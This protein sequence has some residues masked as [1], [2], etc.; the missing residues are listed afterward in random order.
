MKRYSNSRSSN[1]GQSR[2]TGWTDRLASTLHN[3][4]IAIRQLVNLSSQQTTALVSND[5]TRINRIV[6]QQAE[7]NRRLAGLEYERVKMTAELASYLGVLPE[8]AQAL[9]LREIEEMLPDPTRRRISTQRKDL[10][11]LM[12]RL[13]QTNTL[14]SVLIGNILELINQTVQEIV[15]LAT[16]P[17][18]YGGR[19]QSEGATLYLDTKA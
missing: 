5:L 18:G 10:K 3:E 8:K 13:H 12:H 17:P 1:S 19:A 11:R 15:R 9:S 6:E 7:S 14:N 4:L 16:T 2:L